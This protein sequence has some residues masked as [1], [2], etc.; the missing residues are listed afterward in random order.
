MTVIWVHGCNL[1]T[2]QPKATTSLDQA[3]GRTRVTTTITNPGI[4]HVLRIAIPTPTMLLGKPVHATRTILKFKTI[5][6]QINQITLHDG[7]VA[8]FPSIVGPL[9]SN[10]TTAVHGFAIVPSY[11]VEGGIAISVEISFLDPSG[12]FDFIGAGMEFETT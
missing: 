10:S 6:T 9:T 8:L 11:H 7:D 2:D 12:I 4:P 5:N 1:I 3:T